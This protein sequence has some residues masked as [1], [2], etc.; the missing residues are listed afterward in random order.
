MKKR[1]R[2]NILCFIT[3]ISIVNAQIAPALAQSIAEEVANQQATAEEKTT[4]E[5]EERQAERQA[6][7]EL[8]SQQ[9]T[10]E[11]P[12]EKQAEAEGKSISKTAKPLAESTETKKREG[13][14]QI[15]DG[16]E[17]TKEETTRHEQDETAQAD[18]DNKLCITYEENG[19]K[20]PVLRGVPLPANRLDSLTNEILR[21]EIELLKLNTNFRV[22][23]TDRNRIKPWRTFLYNLGASGVST[24]GITT[25]AAERWRTWRKP[26]TGSRTAL[27]A[28]PIMLLTGHSIIAG[29]I[30]LE[31]GLD[32]INDH[33]QKRNGLDPKSTRREAQELVCI[34]DAKL[35][36]RES[37]LSG[38]NAFSE[39]ERNCAREES[40]A[41]I[42]LRNLALSEFCQFHVRAKKRLA[43][44]NFA[45]LNGF[46]AATTGGFLGSLCG[47]LAVSCRKPRLAGPAGIGFTISGANIATGPELGRV[48]SNGAGYLARRS[49]KKEFGEIPKPHLQ[50]HLVALRQRAQSGTPLAVRLSIYDAADG[51]MKKQA[52]M[53]TAE[54]K[55]TD[56]EFLER[57]LYNAA[58]GGSK[59]AWGIQLMNAGY[60]Y[61]TA[62]AKAQTPKQTTAKTMP[63]PI[64]K[65][66]PTRPKK[67]QA[68]LFA[69]RVAQGATSYIP[70]TGLW[71]FDTLQARARGEMDVYTMGQQAAFP[72][73][74]LSER[75]NKITDMETKLKEISQ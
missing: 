60:G 66:F 75:M 36:E 49:L 22:R 45:Y 52:L 5:T 15:A 8:K 4:Q 71:I 6:A 1:S 27:K 53:N 34:I 64:S 39:Q 54:K 63:N 13:V 28:G 37:L 30:L 67:T 46:S 7:A 26:A 68:Q 2:T 29:G 10:A 51:V 33:K 72:H 41:L 48:V 17:A 61:S 74:K 57:C 55:K 50:E 19:G 56:K 47:L 70:G 59:M 40:Q 73:Q 16:Q 69:Q 35:K 32:V 31:A 23:T 44:R 21:C 42:D 25:I 43:G 9:K 11:Q 24:A 20:T 62:V 14:T 65:F 3:L 58:I 38:L 18:P 12:A